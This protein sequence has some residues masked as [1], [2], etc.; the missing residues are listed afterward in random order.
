M[1]IIQLK[2]VLLVAIVIMAFNGNSQS[3]QKEI[4]SYLSK[5]MNDLGLSKSDIKDWVI[6]SQNEAKEFGITYVYTNQQYL[7][8]EI[9]N[10]I[11]NYLIKD[12]K[13]LLTGDRFERNI[14]SR[15][16]TID[17]VLS[18]TQAIQ[19]ASK[20]LGIGDPSALTIETV[21][22]E[23]STYTE[24]SLS[25]VAIP[26][27]LVYA[28]NENGDLRLAWDMSFEIPNGKHYWSARI[29]AVTGILIDKTDWTVS[30]NAGTND[31]SN[32]SH[33]VKATMFTRQKTQT[34]TTTQ[35]ML[36]TV[37]PL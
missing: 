37:G 17:P 6:T 27:K 5:E 4:N 25:R 15:I 36:R 32:H 23:V 2:A 28:K 30:C 31:H 14:E 16:N 35:D 3:I 20:Q 9:Y 19:F 33:V 12:G 7:G 34:T 1:K 13:I 24:S 11:N 29:D 21:V 18:E 22:N 10:A 26:V 8:I